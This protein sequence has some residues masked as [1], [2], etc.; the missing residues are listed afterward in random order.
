MKSKHLTKR[1]KLGTL[2]IFLLI[3][4]VFIFLSISLKERAISNTNDDS[5]LSNVIVQTSTTGSNISVKFKSV[6]GS[7]YTSSDI[8][9]H[10]LAQGKL[11]SNRLVLNNLQPTSYWIV[12]KVTKNN[13]R[14]KKLISI[15][16]SYGL[17]R[18]SITRK[19]TLM[20]T[21]FR[22]V[23]TQHTL[24]SMYAK[25]S[26]SAK[27]GERIVLLTVQ[28]ND[29]RIPVDLS[30]HNFS[31]SNVHGAKVKLVAQPADC[32]VLRG[33]KRKVVL[34]LSGIDNDRAVITYD[35]PNLTL[36]ISFILD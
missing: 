26:H 10:Q 32:K 31:V 36:P 19:P 28:N 18:S 13:I 34:L 30:A 35:T 3:S 15:P 9:E 23:G 16:K 4:I 21:T 33:K 12:I 20:G 22:Y 27:R 1:N 17:A 6:A 2:S 29:Y 14:A 8:N 7:T 5:L 11:S 25:Q 24:F